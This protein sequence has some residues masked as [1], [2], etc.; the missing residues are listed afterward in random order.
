MATL[1]V[2]CV[3]DEVDFTPKT[4]HKYN[5][6]LK[7][8]LDLLPIAY[9]EWA[10]GC[11]KATSQWAYVLDDTYMYWTLDNE[12]DFLKATTIK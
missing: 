9:D 3:P 8:I 2:M 4:N 6:T 5:C 11:S 10:V 12:I 7:K 1:P